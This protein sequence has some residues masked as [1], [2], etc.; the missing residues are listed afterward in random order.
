[1]KGRTK[2]R[3]KAI[4]GPSVVLYVPCGSHNNTDHKSST[5]KIMATNTN[6]HFCT[7]AEAWIHTSVSVLIDV[8]CAYPYAQTD[9]DTLVYAHT[10]LHKHHQYAII[11]PQLLS[12]HFGVYWPRPQGPIK[13]GSA[14]WSQWKSPTP[15]YPHTQ[16]NFTRITALLCKYIKKRS[17][18]CWPSNACFSLCA[19]KWELSII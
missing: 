13:K 1:M 5:P 10:H 6:T 2:Q 12:L 19:F 4:K 8:L 11:V 7:I 9:I 14:V 15:N 16:N 3:R 18:Y 17:T